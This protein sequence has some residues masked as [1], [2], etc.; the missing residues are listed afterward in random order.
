MNQRGNE[1]FPNLLR[2]LSMFVISIDYYQ[3]LSL[4]DGI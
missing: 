4:S 3:W 1:G 2:Y